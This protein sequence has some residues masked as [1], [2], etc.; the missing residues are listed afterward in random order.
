M[1]SM[2]ILRAMSHI[3]SGYIADA[4][5]PGSS[6]AIRS[7]RKYGGKIFWVLA[8]CIAALLALSAV[9]VAANWLGLRDLL[10]PGNES[11]GSGG[12]YVDNTSTGTGEMFPQKTDHQLI[13]LSGFMDS[14][15]AKALAE[16]QAFQDSYD[17]DHAILDSIG[18]G[19]TG[20]V[21]EYGA[22][23]QE[24]L[25]ELERIADKYGL[26]L[27]R[28]INIVSQEELAYRVGGEFLNDEISRAYAY[29]YDDGTF[30]F[31]GDY[32]VE[33]YQLRRVVKGVLDEVALNVGDINEYTQ[34]QY[35]TAGG[36]TLLLALSPTKCL[37]MGDF[38]E[39]F[40]TVNVLN[41]SYNSMSREKLEAMAEC[42]DFTRLKTVQK[43]DMRGDSLPDG[44]LAPVNTDTAD[45]SEPASGDTPIAA[46]QAALRRL[47]EEYQLP[48]GTAVDWDT[49]WEWYSMEENTFAV[50]DIDQDGKQELL[51]NYITALTAGQVQAVYGWDGKGKPLKEEFVDF[52]Y[53]AFYDNGT[54]QANFSHNHGLAGEDF[55]PYTLYVYDGATDTY[56]YAVMV[57]AWDRRVAETDYE[58]NPYP[59]EIDRDGDG[60]VFIV[61][62]Y[63]NGGLADADRGKAVFSK[64]GYEEWRAPYFE[65]AQEIDIPWQA[66][67]EENIAAIG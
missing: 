46:Y 34:W 29:I 33:G 58:G 39:C 18:N 1:K 12:A 31:D 40:I 20:I 45:T 53:T 67:T 48:D 42:I 19:P 28:E 56:R 9:A 11:A 54:V 23:T 66:L 5:A 17:Q 41:Y 64:A 26:G 6:P 22:Y 16:W 65:N 35:T 49:E 57:D 52:P 32:G 59:E 13:S 2:D 62:P 50:L 37:M 7:R 44:T 24:M 4:A 43:P 8:A 51:I 14:P 38:P 61:T 3:D 10:L 21:T 47:R 55:W 63:A 27:H 15:G 36:E 30:Q 25:D 60:I